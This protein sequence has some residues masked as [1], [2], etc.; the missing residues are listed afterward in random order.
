M[1]LDMAEKPTRH[2]RVVMLLIFVCVAI[3]F[4]D[5]G[6]I[7]LTAPMM[8]KELGISPKDMGWILSG[9]GWTYAL[10][11]MPSG[12]LVDRIRPR[13]STVQWSSMAAGSLPTR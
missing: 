7:S 1:T 13:Y 11:Q 10:F 4:L 2:R 9:F 8:G 6:N 12:W 3:T 5:R